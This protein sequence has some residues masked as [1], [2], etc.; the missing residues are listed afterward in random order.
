MAEK[1]TRKKI[2]RASRTQTPVIVEPVTETLPVHTPEPTAVRVKKSYFFTILGVLLLVGLLYFFRSLFVAATVN[3]RPISRL[4]VIRDLERQGGKQALD[5]L[6]IRELIKQKADEKRITIT[7]KEISD[8][9][10][11]IEDQY[12]KQ[13]Q[14][15]DDILKMNGMTR[16]QLEDNIKMQKYIE[17]LVGPISVTDAEVEKFITENQESLPKDQDAQAQKAEI[18]QRLQDEKLSQKAQAYLED[19]KKN[20]KINYFVSY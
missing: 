8:Q 19:I 20:A 15:L 5:G 7:S 2:K 17:K 1:T 3:N 13:G 10:K 14:K 4:D 11:K 18:R 6:I 9:M 12:T 16:T